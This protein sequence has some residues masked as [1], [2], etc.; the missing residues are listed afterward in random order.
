MIKNE[1]I[2]VLERNYTTTPLLIASDLKDIQRLLNI[3]VVGYYFRGRRILSTIIESIAGSKKLHF[4]D[5]REA[6][7]ELYER[8]LLPLDVKENIE[9]LLIEYTNQLTKKIFNGKAQEKFIKGFYRLE[10]I[11]LWF[12]DVVYPR[13]VDDDY[14]IVFES[15]NYEISPDIF[16][17]K[18]IEF[19]NTIFGEGTTR[20]KDE[21]YLEINRINPYLHLYAVTKYT[22]NIIGAL[23]IYPLEDNFL[24]E[25]EKSNKYDKSFNDDE[26]PLE[27]IRNYDSPGGYKIFVDTIVT[28]QNFRTKYSMLRRLFEHYFDLFISLAKDGMYISDIYADAWTDHGKKLAEYYQMK[29]IRKSING[30]VY[31]LSLSP[32]TCLK[33]SKAIPRNINKLLDETNKQMSNEYPTVFISYNH[34]DQDIAKQIKDY[35]E[36]NGLNVVIDFESLA[37]GEK[38]EDFIRRC[39]KDSGVT[40]SI[41]SANSLMSSWVAIET[42]YS[43]YNQASQLRNFL[44]C[45]IDKTIFNINFVDEANNSLSSKINDLDTVIKRR[46]SNNIGIEDLQSERT[47][48][49]RIKNE[50]PFI[51]GMMKERMCA[52]LSDVAFNANIEKIVSEIKTI[53][54][55]S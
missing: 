28:H 40:L 51:I 27:I 9:I 19:N 43:Y 41:V 1:L 6:L 16:N 36:N 22:H 26:I 23:E 5:D 3:D 32:N 42:L 35:F 33:Y 52:D 50:L 44:P 38:I 54:R 13:L 11:I 12:I 39:I 7:I 17:R 18:T 49:M 46:I 30:N 53:K 15:E 2:E 21:D 10:N 24:N 34:N 55:Y 47:R 20:K 14:Y 29:K 25:Y 37:T 48:L 31:K 45:Y 4:T 8:K